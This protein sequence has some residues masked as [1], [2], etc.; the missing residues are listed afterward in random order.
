MPGVKTISA[1]VRLRTAN[2]GQFG[3]ERGRRMTGKSFGILLVDSSN[4]RDL[5]ANMP[6]GTW[7]DARFLLVHF[8]A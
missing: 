3:E 2:D 5:L 4:G 6:A 7:Q 1:S 8:R